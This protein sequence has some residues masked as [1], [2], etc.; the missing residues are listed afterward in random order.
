MI[1]VLSIG[2][3]GY[4]SKYKYSLAVAT[5]GYLSIYAIDVIDVASIRNRRNVLVYGDP[6]YKEKRLK[7]EDEEILLMIQTFI[8]TWD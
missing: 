8:S 3:N 7:Q 6:Y 1:D 5:E 4:L 2:T